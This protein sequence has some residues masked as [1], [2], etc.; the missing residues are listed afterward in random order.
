[1]NKKDVLLYKT[2]EEEILNLI[3]KGEISPG[4]L[5]YSE[6]KLSELFRVSRQ[7]VRKALAKLFDDGIIIK[8][9][10]KGTY[11]NDSL[12]LKKL[13]DGKEFNILSPQEKK[14]AIMTGDIDTFFFEV[15][16]V[17]D[18]RSSELGY[19]P[20]FFIND[21]LEHENEAIDKILSSG[22]Q[23]V[24]FT[25]FRSGGYDSPKNYY[26]FQK[27]GL[28]TVIIGKP[29]VNFHSDS[30]YVDDVNEAFRAL[31]KISTMGYKS[32]IHITNKLHD[33]QAVIER[34]QGY[35]LAVLESYADNQKEVIIDMSEPQWEERFKEEVVNS[36]KPCVL[37]LDTD[38][39]AYPIFNIL[40]KM[41]VE[42]P[43]E[44]GVLGYDNL[45]KI[46]QLPVGLSSVQP[47]YRKMA[48]QAF[49]LLHNKIIYNKE[50]NGFYKHYIF[51][52]ELIIRDSLKM[53]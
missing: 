27:A 8:V 47:P 51:E 19:T 16:K 23:G 48:E 39:I 9:K 31:N 1:M 37:F 17:I 6:N 11:V 34:T 50:Q 15:I 26:R 18:Q 24:I 38:L 22:A 32:A 20:V 43:N 25:P 29:P 35:R 30:V 4:S 42:I 46:I 13:K 7:T 28:K 10:G 44:I 12:D 2:I 5:L 40:D 36:I 21:T 3:I 14:I 52:S 45:H 41:G 53:K 33:I 49:D